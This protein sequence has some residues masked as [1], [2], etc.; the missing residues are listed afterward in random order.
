MIA[1]I[2]K[3]IEYFLTSR[4]TDLKY[5]SLYNDQFNNP[6]S[7]RA[8][9]MPAILIEILPITFKD[10]LNNVQYSEVEVNLH[11]GTEIVNGFDRDDSMQNNSF[12]Y[13]QLLD[14]IYIALNNVNSQ[15][16][17]DELKS[18]IFLQGGLVRTGLQLN[19]YNSTLYTAVIKAKFMLFDCSAVKQYTE[20]E[21]TD[22]NLNTWYIPNPPFEGEGQSKGVI[23]N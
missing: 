16:L 5:V 10:L 19:Q 7:N 3:T 18:D 17:P 20:L 1:N 4:V 11:F 14:K 8:L 9:P 23:I 13:L 6:L 12:E 15:D 21:L 22:I 2:Y